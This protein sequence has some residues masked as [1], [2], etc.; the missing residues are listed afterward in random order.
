MLKWILMFLVLALISGVF[1]F[2]NLAAGAASIAQVLFYVFLVLLVV[3]LIFGRR[4]T[5]PA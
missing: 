5:S 3:S 2:T 1:G 4:A